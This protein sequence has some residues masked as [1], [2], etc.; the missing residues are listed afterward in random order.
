MTVLSLLYSMII[1]PIKLLFEV[2][3]TT[4]NRLT[5]N[6][7]LSIIILSLTVNLLVLPLYKRADELQAEDRDI[8]AKMAPMIK[9]IKKTFKGD[10]RFFMTQEYYR[11]NNYKPIYSLKSSVSLLLQIPFFIAAYDLLSGMS[12][13][14]GLPFSFIS[15]LGMEDAT[16]M[17][18]SFPVNILPI[19]MTLINVISGI[20]YTKGHP[21]K[22][23]VQ[24]YGLAAIFLVLLYHSPSGLVFYW[25]LNNVFSLVK[26]IVGK[27]SVFKLSR[28]PVKTKLELNK[29]NFSL[30]FISGIVLAVLTGVMIPSD[31]VVQN[32]AEMTNTLSA[33]P[34]N[35][36]MYIVVSAFTAIGLFLIWIPVFCVLTPKAEKAYSLILPSIA[37][38]GVVNYIAFN[39]NFGFLSNKLIY[40]SPINYELKEI[41]INL[42]VVIAVTA[43]VVFITIKWRKTTRLLLVVAFIAVSFLSLMRLIAIGI[44][45]AGYNYS[46]SNTAEEVSIPLSTTG[47]NVVVLMIDKMNG[48]YIPYLFNERPDVAEQFDGFT[49]YPNTVS[50]GKFTNTGSPALFG[51]YDYTPDKINARSNVPLVDK[52]NEALLTMPVIFS[53]NGWNVSVVDPSYANYQWKPDLSIYDGYEGI[54][55]YHMSGVFNDRAPELSDVGADQEARLNRN[56]FCY[57]VMKSLPYFMQAA[58]YDSG[59]Y[60]CMDLNNKSYRGNS[61]HVQTGYY[62]WHLQE[63]AALNALSEVTEVTQD[64]TNCFFVMANGS[65]HEVCLLEEPDYSPALYIDNTDYDAAHE[66]RF[67]VDGVTMHMDT[68]YCNYAAYQCSMEACITLGQ[69]FD[70]L[71]ENGVYDNTRI[72]IVADHGYGM[73]QFD[74][75]L[76]SDLG[77]DA[78]SFNPV[79]MVKDFN[80]TGFTVSDEFMTN[81]DT[82]SLAF[83][84]IVA[85]PVNPFTNNPINQDA[86]SGDQLIYS[87]DEVNIYTNNGT[88]FED[89]NGFWLAVHDDIRDEDNWSLYPGEPT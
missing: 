22:A 67:T 41:L 74:D 60:L 43:L 17:I 82:P 28:K 48:S 15:D 44:D 70:Y 5:G 20:L 33:D 83:E 73:G 81:A 1:L 57:G 3:F 66:D 6:I 47:K 36:M 46:Y 10:E 30:V 40:D 64:S 50:F 71:R 8:Q 62:E 53:N 80:C 88:R 39:K 86:K 45:T 13:L 25:L 29:K 34:H 11:I 61:L 63:H 12:N 54:N 9:H 21:L 23:K 42:A 14:Q 58:V 2:I 55:A 19:L 7:G 32:A 79:L 75:L 69:W 65:T 89:S 56:L 76:M 68:H 16:F 38:A 31:V 27:L 26:N 49:Y 85:D 35:P 52:Q 4:A 77:F 24:V 37:T 59:N 51:G 18:G 78:Q 84:G 72:I 87:S